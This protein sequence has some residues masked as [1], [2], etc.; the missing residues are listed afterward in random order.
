MSDVLIMNKRS[1]FLLPMLMTALG[2][3]SV[4]SADISYDVTRVGVNDALSLRARAS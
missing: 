4:G 3:N 1:Y 2:C